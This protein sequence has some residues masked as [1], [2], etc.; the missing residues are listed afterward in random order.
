MYRSNPI[1]ADEGPLVCRR[2]VR[3]CITKQQPVH[4]SESF[5]QMILLYDKVSLYRPGNSFPETFPPFKLQARQDSLDCFL[6]ATKIVCL[7]CHLTSEK[8]MTVLL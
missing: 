4:G 7:R 8:H 5:I 1:E 3:F 2:S 6:R